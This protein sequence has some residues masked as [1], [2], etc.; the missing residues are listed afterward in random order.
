MNHLRSFITPII[1]SIG[2][3][4]TPDGT[5]ESILYSGPLPEALVVL[6]FGE[7]HLYAEIHEE[8]GAYATYDVSKRFTTYLPDEEEYKAIDMAALLKQ[9]KE[10]GNQQRVTQILQ[11]DV[12][13]S[14]LQMDKKI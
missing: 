8:A 11:A 14:S 13:R 9:Y 12:S 2:R 5:Q 10:V 6:P 4:Q 3:S 1:F 7:F